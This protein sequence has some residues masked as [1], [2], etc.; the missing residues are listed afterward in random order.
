VAEPRPPVAY[1]DDIAITRL[2][3]R[4]A[5]RRR[6]QYR[7][8]RSAVLSLLL[9]ATVLVTVD[10]VRDRPR[11]AGPSL[12]TAGVAPIS[13]AARPAERPEPAASAAPPPPAQPSAESALAAPTPSPTPPPPSPTPARPPSD[14][15]GRFGYAPTAGPVLGAA[16]TLRR[17]HVAVEEGMGITAA[18]FAG[19]ADRVLGDERSWIAGGGLRLQRVPRTAT[20][21]FTLYLA[22]AGT[23]ERMCAQ[24]GLD[25]DRYTSCR[26][27]GRVVINADRWFMAIEGYGAPLSVYQD[28]VINHEVGHQLG[29]GHEAC[30]GAGKPA[31][32]MQQQTL[33]LDG[34]V[35]NSWPYLNGKRYAGLP[36]P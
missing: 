28:Y 25:T 26:L 5:A 29:H 21:E 6:M 7:R 22:S 3:R 16:G 18:T 14:G 33:G 1:E 32:V 2:E 20:A 19:A 23:S 9:L 15:S 24:G 8:R 11:S 12:A 30:S 36:V 10:L 13:S 35:A 4:R 34:C 27:P 31:P 17:F